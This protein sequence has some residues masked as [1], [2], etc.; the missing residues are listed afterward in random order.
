MITVGTSTSC[1]SPL[2]VDEAFRLA[3]TTGFD[4]VEVMVT[5]DRA[6]RDARLLR[7]SSARWGLPVLSVHAPVLPLAH[8]ALGRDQGEK[9]RRSAELAVELGASTVVVHPPFRWQRRHSARFLGLVRELAASTGVELAVENMFPWRAGPIVADVYSPGH[10]PSTLDV[11]AAVLDFS[12]AAVA[13]RD[14]LD[15]ALA[16]GPRLRHVHL[17]DGVV[18]TRPGGL[19]DQH[20][21]PGT[22]DQPVAEVLEH[23]ARSGWSG[24][25]VAEVHSPGRTTDEVALSDMLRRTL[26]HARAA[27]SVGATPAAGTVPAGGTAT[28]A[29]YAPTSTV[30]TTASGTA[31]TATPSPPSTTPRHLTSTPIDVSLPCQ[32][33]VASEAQ[34]A[35]RQPTLTPTSTATSRSGEPATGSR[36]R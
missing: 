22:G 17:C 9:L 32:S 15:L 14:A 30:A 2:P 1:V 18:S 20:L 24:S 34:G 16:L 11:D 27:L 33:S 28:S 36:A 26:A 7:D 10:D 6:S 21:V 25:V 3:R 31:T 19:V 13:G 29:G 23:L 8:F 4:G 5:A 12:H 35:T